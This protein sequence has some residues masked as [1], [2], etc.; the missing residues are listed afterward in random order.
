MPMAPMHE[1]A[2]RWVAWHRQYAEPRHALSRRLRDIQRQ[3]STYL[4]TAPASGLS[5]LSLCAGQGDD[6]LGVL[7]NHPAA[8]RV[9]ANLVELEEGNVSIA[10]ERIDGLGLD[11]VEVHQADAGLSDTYAALVPADLVLACG[12][13]GNLTDEDV[14]ATIA[15]LPQLCAADAYVI[16]TRHRRA[17]DLTPTI[18]E[19]FA[20][21]GFH[22]LRFHSPDNDWWAV[23]THRLVS[24][25]QPLRLGER[26][27]RF[28]DR[29]QPG[30]PE[31]G[32]SSVA[33]GPRQ[34]S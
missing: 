32:F 27:F 16:W 14:A 2:P 22:K 28:V 7:P 34:G 9:R 25:P 17:P 18:N 3:I 23:G 4:D 11:R 6:L 20:A 19:W 12:V 29:D 26:W 5:I 15:A 24:E 31:S 10:R 8:A 1:P 33:G 30:S 21:A 13:F